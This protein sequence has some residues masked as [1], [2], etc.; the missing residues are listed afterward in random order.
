MCCVCIGLR[1]AGILAC[2][3]CR[4]TI[5]AHFCLCV[6]Q[7]YNE[8]EFRLVASSNLALSNGNFDGKTYHTSF[9]TH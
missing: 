2:I 8:S 9:I 4:D 6:S 5:L 7:L 1:L 3:V